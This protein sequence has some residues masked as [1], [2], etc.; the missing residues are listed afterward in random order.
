VSVEAEGTEEI[1]RGVRSELQELAVKAVARL[2]T[3]VEEEEWDRAVG[4][5]NAIEYVLRAAKEWK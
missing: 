4:A 2:L 3:F 1:R 5:L